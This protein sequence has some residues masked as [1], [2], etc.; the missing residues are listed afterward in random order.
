VADELEKIRKHE[1]SALDAI[2]KKMGDESSSESSS[3]SPKDLIPGTQN[4]EEQK[5]KA[6]TSQKVQQE[7][8]NLRQQLGQR[9]TVKELPKDLDD[10]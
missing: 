4:D 6:Q 1:S 10:A 3:L 9:K 5:R 7:I 2:R 8:E